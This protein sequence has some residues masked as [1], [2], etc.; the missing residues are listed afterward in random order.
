MNCQKC[1]AIV[2]GEF[3]AECG[4][5]VVAASVEA[6]GVA[7]AK[8]MALIKIVAIIVLAIVATGSGIFGFTQQGQVT[9]FSQA[10][11][12]AYQKVSDYEDSVDTWSGLLAD[13]EASKT[14]CY[15]NYWCS[16]STYRG[17]IDLVNLNQ[18]YYTEAQASVSEWQSKANIART[19]RLAAES[20]RT[21]GFVASG[22]SGVALLVV[23]I[24]LVRRK[25]ANS[26]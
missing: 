10:E 22:I 15:Y 8:S 24:F 7:P 17:W 11:A 16:A 20:R 5:K 14:T 18:N 25:P 3:C 21:M 26:L 12:A 13:A 2:E 9:T 19:A 4:A 23:V 6:Q 1:N